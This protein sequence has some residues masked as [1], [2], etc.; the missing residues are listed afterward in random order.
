M[1][2]YYISYTSPKPT[3]YEETKILILVQDENNLQ[4]ILP[5]FCLGYPSH[6][7]ISQEGH[8]GKEMTISDSD[9]K[10]VNMMHS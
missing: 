2:L 10:N 7:Q 5:E 8:A 6:P 4:N 9:L 3:H 1:N